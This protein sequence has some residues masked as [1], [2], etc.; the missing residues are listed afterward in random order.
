MPKK[1][2]KRLIITDES[3]NKHK[4]WT[5]TAGIEMAQFEKNPLLL[6]MHMRPT[7]GKVDDVLALGHWDD[8]QRNDQG[9]ISGVPVFDDTD[10]FAMRIFN[11]VE[12]GHYRMASAG[13]EVVNFTDESVHLKDGA[14]CLSQ[15]VLVE[16][17]IVDIGS[18]NNA[19]AQVALYDATTKEI[20]NLNAEN[21][22]MNLFKNFKTK[23]T[24]SE[25]KFEL[26]KL[27]GALGLAADNVSP[28]AIIAKAKELTA[29]AQEVVQLKA[30]NKKLSDE[31]V[32]LKTAQDTA[33][34]NE[35]VEGAVAEGKITEKQ[36]EAYLKLAAADYESAKEAL[37]AMP[38]HTPAQQKMAAT[39]KASAED[40]LLKLSWD[41]AHKA[42]KLEAIKAKH[43][44][45]FKT[46]K[47]AWLADK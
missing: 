46:L 25:Q 35:L 45:H 12:G 15:S 4:F 34:V 3:V 23:N 11:K 43:P 38:G 19:L 6:F 1:S 30:D 32:E 9:Q 37:D 29:T 28:E 5:K 31:V 8:I 42:G 22:I 47:E 7:T 24:M 17:S 41:E 39:E 33:K 2:S 10:D 36:K 18:N 20:I 14:P 44:E 16:A 27:G 21:D 40:P 13:L 26:N